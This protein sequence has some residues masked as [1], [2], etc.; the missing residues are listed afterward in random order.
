[1]KPDKPKETLEER[2]S[3]LASRIDGVFYQFTNEVFAHEVL[4]FIKQELKRQRENLIK[5]IM[6]DLLTVWVKV[7]AKLYKD[8]VKIDARLLT[9]IEILFMKYLKTLGKEEKWKE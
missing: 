1:M 5:E 9:K 4:A 7:R 3:P 2:F 6:E 8:G